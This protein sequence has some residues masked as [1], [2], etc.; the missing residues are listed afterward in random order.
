MKKK[1]YLIPLVLVVL[2]L[3]VPIVYAATHDNQGQKPPSSGAVQM[4]DEESKAQDGVQNNQQNNQN[5]DQEPVSSEEKKEQSEST[6]TTTLSKG[7]QSKQSIKSN[8]STVKQPSSSK[9]GD[10]QKPSSGNSSSSQGDQNNGPAP[11]F[12]RVSITI[13]DN[14]KNIRYSSAKVDVKEKGSVLDALY[15]TGVPCKVKPNGYV[16]EISGLGENRNTGGGWMY[17]VNGGDPP[18]VGAASYTVKNGDCIIW[19]YGRFG[20]KPPKL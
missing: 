20:E 10:Q 13:V 15:A 1:T 4:S 9:Q 17:A 18:G 12:V 16:E 6:G 5:E 2:G 19:Y 14:N 11:G 3:L 8:Q 7:N